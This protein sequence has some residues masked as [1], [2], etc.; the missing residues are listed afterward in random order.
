LTH[1]LGGCG[2]DRQSVGPALL[3]GVLVGARHQL[4]GGCGFEIVSLLRHLRLLYTGVE[5][6]TMPAGRIS[7]RTWSFMR[8]RIS[9]GGSVSPSTMAGSIA[10]TRAWMA[11]G[12]SWRMGLGVTAMTAYGQPTVEAMRRPNT[13]N[14]SVVIITVG[15][16]RL[17]RAAVTWLHHVVHDPQSPVAAT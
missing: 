6:L 11:S 10:A 3:V 8:S 2:N 7:R 17:S 9:A 4:C 15:T 16:P 5:D 13:L 1:T 12:S 14:E